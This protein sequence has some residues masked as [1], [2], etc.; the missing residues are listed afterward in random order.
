MEII[1]HNMDNIIQIQSTMYDMQLY[2]LHSMYYIQDSGIV[3]SQEIV[4]CWKRKRVMKA[5][6]YTLGNDVWTNYNI[7]KGSE[8]TFIQW[9]L[10][11]VSKHSK[12]CPISLIINV[13]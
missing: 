12:I 9:I 8:Q 4:H 6:W 13:T 3:A 11:V 1:L 10:W 2:M 5:L 7:D